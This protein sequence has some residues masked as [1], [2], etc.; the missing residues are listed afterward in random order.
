MTKDDKKRFMLIHGKVTFL[1]DKKEI[2][3]TELNTVAR[4]DPSTKR[5]TVEDIKKIQEALIMVFYQR[6][7]EPEFKIVD[8]TIHN[9]LPMGTMTEEEFGGPS[10]E[11]AINNLLTQTGTTH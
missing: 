6:V 8:V 1:D 10:P 9:I 7:Q 2:G 4:L 11:D 3:S 5:I